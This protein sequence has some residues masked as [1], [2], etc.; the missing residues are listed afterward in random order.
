MITNKNNAKVA[1][2]V[3]P[4]E[5]LDARKYRYW[6]TL[7]KRLGESPSKDQIRKVV[8]YGWHTNVRVMTEAKELAA[9]IKEA[10]Q[11]G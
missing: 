10:T 2:H 1:Q 11:N 3:N 8:A 4:F 5:G 9:E 6:Q 7:W